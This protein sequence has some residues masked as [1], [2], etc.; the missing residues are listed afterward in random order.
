MTN[1]E[2]VAKVQTKLDIRTVIIV[3]LL[4]FTVGAYSAAPQGASATDSPPTTA[5]T[6]TTTAVVEKA[7]ASK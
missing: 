6:T 5:P 3:G 2:T 1:S 4:S 7:L